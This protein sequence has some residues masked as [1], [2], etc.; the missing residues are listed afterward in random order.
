[1]WAEFYLLQNVYYAN[2]STENLIQNFIS[3]IQIFLLIE[4]NIQ[5]ETIEDKEAHLMLTKIAEKKKL[6]EEQNK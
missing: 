3:P 1:M 5:C 2:R 6:I 4:K